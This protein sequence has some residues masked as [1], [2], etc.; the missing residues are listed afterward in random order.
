MKTAKQFIAEY[1]WRK[2]AYVVKGKTSGMYI[3]INGLFERDIEQAQAFKSYDDAMAYIKGSKYPSWLY[4]AKYT[5]DA[6]DD[7]DIDAE[8]EDA[9]TDNDNNSDFHKCSSE[10]NCD[11]DM[12]Y[13]FWKETRE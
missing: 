6:D 12:A 7:N 2:S 9:D 4:P 8:D 13:D 3:D 10:I 5:P 11:N 1:D